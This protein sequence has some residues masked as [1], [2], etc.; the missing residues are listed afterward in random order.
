MLKKNKKNA[1]KCKTGDEGGG[2]SKKMAEV[3]EC[4]RVNKTIQNRK[5]TTVFL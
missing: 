3:R 1:K 5:K 4:E 2:S